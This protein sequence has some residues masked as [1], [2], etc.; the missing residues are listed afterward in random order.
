MEAEVIVPG[1]AVPLAADAA[2]AF[3][4]AEQGGG[5]TPQHP[6]VFRRSAILQSA[7]VFSKDHVQHPVQS[8]LNPQCPRVA[9]PNSSALP[10]R[11]QM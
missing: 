9:L 2:L 11:L 7:V 4:L 1:S 10:L 8:I 6:Q 3:V 5:H